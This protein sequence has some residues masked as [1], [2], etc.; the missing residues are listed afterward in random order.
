MPRRSSNG[1]P[2]HIN[3]VDGIGHGLDAKI[4]EAVSEYRCPRTISVDFQIFES[5]RF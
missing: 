2:I 3:V 1:R 5:C 4:I